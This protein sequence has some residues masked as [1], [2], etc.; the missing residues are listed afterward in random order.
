MA[1]GVAQLTELNP[2]LPE[3]FLNT[4]PQ[5]CNRC[6]VPMTISETLTSLRCSN[7][8]CSSKHKMRIKA[9]C[10][11]LDIKG[12]GEAA[13][14]S[15]VDSYEPTSPMNIFDLQES[16][17]VGRNVGQ[18]KSD[19]IIRQLDYIK[20]SRTFLLW[21]VVRLLHMPGIQTSAQPIFTD[22]SSIDE[23]Y[24][25]IHNGGVEYIHEKLY[26][27]VVDSVG[28]KSIQ[29]YT[30]LIEMEEDVKEAVG[31]FAI[32]STHD[33]PE[34]TVVASDQVGGDFPTKSAFYN[35]CKATYPGRFHFNFASSVSRKT[36]DCLIWAGAD[37]SD[38]RYTSK[39]RKVEGYNEK[40]GSGIPILTA[41]Q[42]LEFLDSGR[43][44]S[45]MYDFSLTRNSLAMEDVIEYEDD[46]DD[47]GML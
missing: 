18:A 30:T 34:L 47:I 43:P 12:F 3:E 42:F 21:E 11:D 25:E 19:E 13:I 6:W 39:V 40:Y 22:A 45:E 8:R 5:S 27:P 41:T 35:H 32:T 37:G 10:K 1:I 14:E 17:L 15:F 23:A 24:E 2:D 36:T 38:A 29:V 9:I 44:V 4:L 7:P 26:G 16:M 46:D 28:V 31:Y 20:T 33:A